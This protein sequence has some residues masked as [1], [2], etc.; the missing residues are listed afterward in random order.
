MKK[1]NAIYFLL[2]ILLVMGAFASMAQNGYG[3]KIMGG[4][5]L[6]FGVLFLLE[7]VTEL[8]K[9]ETKDGYALAELAAMIIFSAIFGCRVFNIHFP[10]IEFLFAGAGA[11][12]VF[13]YLRKLI[14]RYKRLV[15][16]NRRLAWL[17]LIFHMSIILFLISL[18]LVP[19][20]SQKAEWVGM[21]AFALLLIFILGAFMK[22]DD[23]VDGNK[24]TT[25]QMVAGYRDHSI[26]LASLFLLFSLFAAFNKAGL[27]PGIYSD[28]FPRA[29]F[30]LVDKA[31]TGKEKPV[32]GKYKHELFKNEYD[33]FIKNNGA[34]Q[35]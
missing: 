8:G 11:W 12:L 9:K 28:E 24:V 6:A 20:A 23:L 7:F 14:I 21:A 34:K 29:Y 30:E 31:T 4:V 18:I 13:F 25:M 3:L 27:V 19:F 33:Q 5:A 2:F 17:G 22:R 26:V 35:K 16:R 15:F 32:D 1:F 10:Y